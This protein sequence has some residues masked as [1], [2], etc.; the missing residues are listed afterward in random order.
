MNN[1]H[2][3]S[4]YCGKLYNTLHYMIHAYSL[5]VGEYKWSCRKQDYN[6]WLLCDGRELSTTEY[7]ELFQ[8]IGYSF[9]GHGTI[10]NLP[11]LFGR[12]MGCVGKGSGLSDRNLGDAIGSETHVLTEAEIPG[13]THK[14]TTTVNGS[15]NHNGST[16]VNGLHTHSTNGNGGQGGLGLCTADGQNTAISTDNGTGE[17]NVFTTPRA[18]QVNGTGDHSHNITTDGT[19]TH[20][21]TTAVTGLGQ[22]HDNMQPTLYAGNVFIFCGS[23]I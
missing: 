5:H 16:S 13:H 19:H 11:N 15:H 1:I 21:F 10:F 22:S 4:Q 9:G 17:L 23:L 20:T 3:L 12:V 2:T 6:G 14:G 18:I 7:P 8:V